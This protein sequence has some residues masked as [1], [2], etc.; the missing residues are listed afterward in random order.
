MD[1]PHHIGEKLYPF[2]HIIGYRPANYNSDRTRFMPGFRDKPW[3]KKTEN[4]MLTFLGAW[5]ALTFIGELKQSYVCSLVLKR[6]SAG[7]EGARVSGQT[8]SDYYWILRSW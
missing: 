2:S 1:I 7:C 6:Y 4:C 5:G 3:V 8:C